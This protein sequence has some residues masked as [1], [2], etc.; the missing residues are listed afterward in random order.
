[1][2]WREIGKLC[3]KCDVYAGCNGNSA[4]TQ[5]FRG[6]TCCWARIGAVP[7][8][9]E[10]ACRKA[11]KFGARRQNREGVGQKRS[12]SDR[13][14]GTQYGGV[15]QN[16]FTSSTPRYY[17]YRYKLLT[18][19]S[20]FRFTFAAWVSKSLYYFPPPFCSASSTLSQTI[21][22]STRR[23]TSTWVYSV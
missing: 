4:R 10:T 2:K 22:A 3:F 1:M 6:L 20:T 7:S 9:T 21:L 13:G 12:L 5:R 18:E 8:L 23:L 15:T 14:C 11:Q 19:L 17:T 16:I